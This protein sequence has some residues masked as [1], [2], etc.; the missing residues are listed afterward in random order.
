MTAVQA[1][2]RAGLG[3]R[4]GAGEERT[5]NMRSMVLTLEVSKFSGWLKAFA[6]RNMACMF[7]TLEVLKLSSWLNASASCRESKGGH[8]VRGEVHGSAV[9]RRRVTTAQAAC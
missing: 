2:C 4:L 3:C 6:S 7:L 8:A 1:A 9:E 5:K